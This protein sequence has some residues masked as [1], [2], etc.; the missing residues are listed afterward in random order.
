[1]KW[2]VLALQQG[3][4]HLSGEQSSLELALTG[5]MVPEMELDI[6]VQLEGA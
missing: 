5:R 4:R 3:R 1:M 6:L 2:E